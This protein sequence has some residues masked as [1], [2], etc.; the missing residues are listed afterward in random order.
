MAVA[1]RTLDV[2]DELKKRSI[3]KSLLEDLCTK[4]KDV[5]ENKKTDGVTVRMKEEAW[6]K[7]AVKFRA[8]STTGCQREWIQLNM[9]VFYFLY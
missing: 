9:Y 8:T 1:E 5:I 3:E 4:Y 6:Q 7:R 2:S